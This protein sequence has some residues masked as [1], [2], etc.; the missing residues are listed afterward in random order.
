MGDIQK[1]GIIMVGVKKIHDIAIV[2][3]QNMEL[4]LYGLKNILFYHSTYL[5]KC[6][7][8]VWGETNYDITIVHVKK[9]WYYH[10]TSP[11]AW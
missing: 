1:L 4:S 9:T 5:N 6:I 3:V 10:G 2:L 8:M 11:K 7:I